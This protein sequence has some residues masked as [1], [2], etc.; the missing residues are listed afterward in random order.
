M[1]PT[2]RK[3]T[4][5]V[6]EDFNVRTPGMFF[7]SFYDRRATSQELLRILGVLPN[8]ASELM[9]HPGYADPALL[10]GSGYTRQREQELQLLT[11]PAIKKT[12]QQKGIRLITFADLA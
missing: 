11:D 12:I 4:P 7:A 1:Q 9:C 5:T 10:S 3:F 6:L 2:I 8:G